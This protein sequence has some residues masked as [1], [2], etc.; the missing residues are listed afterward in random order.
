[1]EPGS[2]TRLLDD[3]QAGVAGAEDRLFERVYG[4]LKLMAAAR[5]RH[6]RPGEGVLGGATDLA[7]E[8][9]VRLAKVEFENR[10]H[11]FFAYARAMRQI[12]IDA[13][14]TRRTLKRGGGAG[15]V[16]FDEAQ[17]AAGPA[18]SAI[19]A[20]EVARL[21]DRLRSEEPRVAEVVQ[22]RFFGGLRDE[23][24]AELLEVDVR[25]VRRDWAAARQRFKNWMM[26][27]GRV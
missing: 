26:A 19:D 20:E 25:T 23:D 8:A 12:L 7:H 1:M 22:L 24:I 4:E 16:P 27:G 11:L 2:I 17:T 21:L 18:S 9:H 13:S 15:L 10:R 6:E 5:I 14:R 3:V